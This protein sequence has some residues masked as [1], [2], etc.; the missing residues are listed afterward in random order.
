MVASDR[1][2]RRSCNEHS[3]INESESPLQCN[4]P[5]LLHWSSNNRYDLWSLLH[6]GKLRGGSFCSFFLKNITLLGFQKNI[7]FPRNVYRI[8]AITL[9]QYID[10]VCSSFY[11]S[12]LWSFNQNIDPPTFPHRRYFDHIYI[13]LDLL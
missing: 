3:L 4:L 12:I 8:I 10:C 6:I 5:V 2:M 7:L 13:P 9:H 11:L 1:K